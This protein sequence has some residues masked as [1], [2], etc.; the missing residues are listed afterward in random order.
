MNSIGKTLEYHELLMIYSD[1][2]KFG[3][4]TLPNGFHYEFYKLGDEEEWAKIHVESGEF[5]SIEQ[6]FKT[7]NDFY[8]SF[9]NEL[10]KRMF[11]CC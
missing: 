1:T 3:K 2:S 10:P 11:F 8:S 9:L 4:D 5:M 7:F 6:G